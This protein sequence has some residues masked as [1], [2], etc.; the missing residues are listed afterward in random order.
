MRIPWGHFLEREAP[1]TDLEPHRYIVAV[2]VE[3]DEES[4]EAVNVVTTNLNINSANPAYN[5]KAMAELTKHVEAWQHEHMAR[6]TIEG[7]V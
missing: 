1:V 7:P 3:E 4:G 5:K 2:R 6:V